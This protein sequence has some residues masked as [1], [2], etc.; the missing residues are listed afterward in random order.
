MSE[1]D[2]HPFSKGDLVKLNV[3]GYYYQTTWDTL[4]KDD[5]SMLSA[6][7]AGRVPVKVLNDGSVFIDR[8][9]KM[10]AKILNFLRNGMIEQPTERRKILELQSEAEFYQLQGL[11]EQIQEAIIGGLEYGSPLGKKTSRIIGKQV[12]VIKTETERDF[13]LKSMTDPLVILEVSSSSFGDEKDAI[14]YKHLV[15]FDKL[16]SDYGDKILFV[17]QIVYTGKEWKFY[18]KGKLQHSVF[19]YNQYNGKHSFQEE[20]ILDRILKLILS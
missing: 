11:M 1:R 12:T 16:S 7:F 15:L 9:G 17:K 10:F 20:I 8:D 3:G 2:G 5:N 4:T 19:F 13:L 14:I 18:A 6:M